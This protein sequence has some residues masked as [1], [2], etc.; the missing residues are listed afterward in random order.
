[1]NVIQSATNETTSVSFSFSAKTIFLRSHGATDSVVTVNGN[2]FTLYQ[3]DPYVA[4][5][6]TSMDGFVVTSGAVS[7]IALG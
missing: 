7:Y 1:M 6:A 4:L 5:D 2:S 3:D